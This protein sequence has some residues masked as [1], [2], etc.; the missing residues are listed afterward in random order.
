MKNFRFLITAAMLSFALGS[1]VHAG[2]V[3]QWEA[4]YKKLIKILMATKTVGECSTSISGSGD[5]A[6]PATYT[7]NILT[8]ANGLTGFV[9]DSPRAT[10]GESRV[11]FDLAKKQALYSV[12]DI[13]GWTNLAVYFDA[14]KHVTGLKLYKALPS[15]EVYN[16]GAKCGVR[17][18]D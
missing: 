3:S 14:Q 10:A 11:T 5:P 1:T 13:G 12:S 9:L 7:L 4:N 16:T 17:S 18:D 6:T 2:E 8:T 15:G